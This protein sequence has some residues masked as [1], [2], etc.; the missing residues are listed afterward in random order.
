MTKNYYT[1]FDELKQITKLFK[2]TQQNAR[3]MYWIT[4]DKFVDWDFIK[5]I[6]KTSGRQ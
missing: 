5:L 1:I 2:R 4:Y 3:E 6:I